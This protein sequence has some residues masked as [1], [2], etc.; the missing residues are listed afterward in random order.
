MAALRSGDVTVRGSESFADHRDQLLTIEESR[1]LLTGY[2]DRLGLPKTASEFVAHLK[3]ALTSAAQK[4]DSGFLLN[5]ELRINVKGEPI[6]RRTRARPVPPAAVNLQATI[7]R[8]SPVAKPW[9]CAIL[10][11]HE[12]FRK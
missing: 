1:E 8:I 9:P 5:D 3:T 4:A 12:F 6:V 10:S 2:C 11:P 7:Q